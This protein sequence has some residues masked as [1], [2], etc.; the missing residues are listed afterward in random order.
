MIPIVN[1]IWAAKDNLLA[2]I[3][4]EGDAEESSCTLK[5]Y[6]MAAVYLLQNAAQL[7]EMRIEIARQ[8]RKQF[9]CQNVALQYDG[10]LMGV[11]S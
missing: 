10:W 9:D 3:G 1:P 5:S 4:I 7:E 8:A 2:G 11:M 6:A